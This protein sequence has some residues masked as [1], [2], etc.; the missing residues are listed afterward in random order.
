M[1]GPTKK[2][3]GRQNIRHRLSSCIQDINLLTPFP[4]SPGIPNRCTTNQ[5]NCSHNCT[6]SYEKLIFRCDCPTPL[7]LYQDK[8]TC[9]KN[10]K[11]KF[12]SVVLMN[13]VFPLKSILIFVLLFLLR[14]LQPVLVRRVQYI[15][16]CNRSSCW[17]KRY[18]INSCNR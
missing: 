1:L 17:Y 10:G 8:I 2:I 13:I 18:C 4:L 9:G 5:L 15:C 11:R 16:Q 3:F 12:P 14:H 6:F 7:V